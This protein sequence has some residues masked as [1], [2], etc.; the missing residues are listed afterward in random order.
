MSQE[1]LN[2]TGSTGTSTSGSGSG[3]GAFSVSG[4]K[5]KRMTRISLTHNQSSGNQGSGSGNQGGYVSKSEHRFN[6]LA[7]RPLAEARVKG[8]AES[9]L[10]S[11]HAANA[12]Q[13]ECSAACTNSVLAQY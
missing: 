5:E 1:N 8:G 7:E 11:L 12:V 2:H 4:P 6:P 10:S 9:S 13:V 3:S